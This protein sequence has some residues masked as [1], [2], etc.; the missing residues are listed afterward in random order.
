[1]S[2]CLRHFYGT[3]LS[4]WS[5]QQCGSD[6]SD[7]FWT[8]PVKTVTARP[9]QIRAHYHID[10]CTGINNKALLHHTITA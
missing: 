3:S 6:I 4:Y 1:M 5:T 9:V 2:V 10:I 8:R 7:F